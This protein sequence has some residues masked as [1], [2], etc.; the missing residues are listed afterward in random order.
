MGQRMKQSSDRPV[1]RRR[2]PAT[3]LG[4][5]SEWGTAEPDADRVGALRR[6]WALTRWVILVVA[7][8]LGIAVLI[9]VVITILLTLLNASV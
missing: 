1:S 3:Q 5:D 7:V 6:G 8:G 4:S 9:S 2:Q